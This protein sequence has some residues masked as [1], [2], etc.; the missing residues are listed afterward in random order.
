MF[1]EVSPGV[2]G[3]GV[4]HL[5]GLGERGGAVGQRRAL[6]GR[7]PISRGG[8]RLAAREEERQGPVIFK[9]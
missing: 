5:Q 1:D 3:N 6:L 7:G 2:C 4:D 9:L 8:G